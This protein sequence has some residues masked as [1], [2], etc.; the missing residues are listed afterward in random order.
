MRK[1]LATIAL[2]FILSVAHADEQQMSQIAE[3]SATAAEELVSALK[4]VKDKAT[5]NSA[6]PKVSE[7]GSLLRQ[8]QQASKLASTDVT[9][10]A[11]KAISDKFAERQK[12]AEKQLQAEAKRVEAISEA[13]AVLRDTTF[14][15]LVEDRRREERASA[16]LKTLTT[17]VVSYKLKYGEFPDKL[18]QLVKPPDGAPFL[19]SKD[20]LLDPWGRP[21]EYDA[22]GPK[23]KGF[24]IDIWSLG[25]R[26]KK[27]PIIGN[28]TNETE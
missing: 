9:K 5:A 20:A 22:N 21:Y 2:I 10:E 13:Y 17:A 11:L 12:R 15:K 25:S 24:L 8:C 26:L 6:L 27:G 4:S 3:K 14:F 16:E 7:L 1:F 18:E 19:K 23:H 28:W